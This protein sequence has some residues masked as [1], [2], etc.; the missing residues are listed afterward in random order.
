MVGTEGV[1]ALKAASSGCPVLVSM[2]VGLVCFAR[3]E[4]CA[5]AIADRVPTMPWVVSVLHSATFSSQP[6]AS[7]YDFRSSL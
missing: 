4:A 6:Q 1:S 3:V 2:E 5:G 7:S